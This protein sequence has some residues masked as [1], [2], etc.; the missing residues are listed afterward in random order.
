MWIEKLAV[1]S[2]YLHNAG[3]VKSSFNQDKLV[4]Q[5]L[6]QSIAFYTWLA[7]LTVYTSI[8]VHIVLF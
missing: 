8:S 6:E 3:V 7:S 1:M 5:S 4:N 2:R